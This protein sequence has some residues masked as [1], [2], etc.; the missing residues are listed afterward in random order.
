MNQKHFAEPE[1]CIEFDNE[2]REID[3]LNEVAFLCMDLEFHNNADLS[4][5]FFETYNSIFPVVLTREDEILFMLYKAYRANVRAKVN[6]LN[7]K[8]TPDDEARQQM[9]ETAVRFLRAMRTYLNYIDGIGIDIKKG[10]STSS[11]ELVIAH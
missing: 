6:I 5:L 2:L 7:A 9:I 10:K 11:S 1:E 4:Q 3:V 8:S